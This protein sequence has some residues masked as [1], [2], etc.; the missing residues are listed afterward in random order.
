MI[1]MYGIYNRT[2]NEF[3]DRHYM[4]AAAHELG[5]IFGLTHPSVGTWFTLDSIMSPGFRCGITGAYSTVTNVD[6]EALIR[7]YATNRSQQ[8]TR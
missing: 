3:P 2:G 6:V 8:P 4:F 1:W 7:A 5:H